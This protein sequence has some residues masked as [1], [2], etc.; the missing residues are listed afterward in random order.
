MN[1]ITNETQTL[2]REIGQGVAS[3]RLIPY[4]GP[5]VLE[6]GEEDCP[7]PTSPRELVGLLT[8]KVGVPGRIRHNL[9]S[10]AQY[11]ESKRHRKTLEAL[12][13][14]IF[15]PVPVASPIHTWLAS[16]ETC[17]LIVDTWYD[18]TMGAALRGSGRKDW[19]QVQGITRNGERR[20]IWYKFFH[21]MTGNEAEAWES[22]D[23]L[24]T[25]YKPHGSVDPAKNYLLSD[26]DYVEVLTEIDIQTPIPDMVKDMRTTRGFVFLGCRFY[27]QMLRTYARQIIKRSQ[28]PFYVLLD[29]DADLT[30]NEEKFFDEMN[31]LPI[32]IG[33][34]E[35]TPLLAGA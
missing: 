2:V 24:T 5:G 4:I 3:G 32:R 30:K 23:W 15:G 25:L 19:G 16:L 21:G 33:L 10:S 34:E 26:S 11:I 17:P 18:G 13:N 14:D 7:V 6:T 29:H 27:D 9:W 1:A 31:I 12:L 35:A 28:G 20:D 22:G 8:T